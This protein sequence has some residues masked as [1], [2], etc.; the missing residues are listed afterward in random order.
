MIRRSFAWVALASALAPAVALAQH[1]PGILERDSHGRV[2]LAVD[3]SGQT[4][5][6]E[7]EPDGSRQAWIGTRL[8]AVEKKDGTVVTHA[9]DSAG[10]LTS[11][12]I[13]EGGSA[14][15]KPRFIKYGPDRIAV[16]TPAGITVKEPRRTVTYDDRGRLQY[17][18][19]PQGRRYT[20][21]KA[22]NG[23]AF[24]RF[25]GRVERIE[26]VDGTEIS[27]AYSEDGR[28][29]QKR[30]TPPGQK[31]RYEDFD[32][33]T[34]A[35]T[36][37]KEGVPVPPPSRVA[38]NTTRTTP[39]VVQT[40]STTSSSSGWITRYVHNDPNGSVRRMTDEHGNVTD[41]YTYSASGELIAHTGTDPQPYGFAGLPRQP[42]T[43]LN[44]HRARWMAPNT[45]RF[46]SMDPARGFLDKPATLHTYSYA[47]NDPVNRTDPSGLFFDVGSIS[48]SLGIMNTLA[49]IT[50]FSLRDPFVRPGAFLLDR[51]TSKQYRQLVGIIFAESSTPSH[52]GG[53]FH[54]EKV[55]IGQ[56]IGNRTFY[57]T[58]A[59]PPP[60]NNCANGG[61]G[62]GTVWSAISAPGQ[63]EA[64]SGGNGARWKLVMSGDDLSRPR[65]SV[66]AFRG[67]AIASTST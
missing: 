39:G 57:A 59:P 32:Y 5:R 58:M 29:V 31:P 2:R 24:L 64:Y 15:T 53:E 46:L 26:K 22:S 55:A 35:V 63:F 67:L 12:R 18:I 48:A 51:P 21:S 40:T 61:F 8:L 1:R 45:G 25:N 56:T 36:L 4:I 54:D 41:A 65:H 16:A 44:Y 42:E 3:E 19:D 62:S 20:V 60:Y 37:D 38:S 6:L 13:T 11:T 23:D 43:N 27:Y 52:G 50:P 47:G 33:G 30:I 34:R 9:Y 28:A 7:Y 10:R 14:A 66:R 49:G 17:V